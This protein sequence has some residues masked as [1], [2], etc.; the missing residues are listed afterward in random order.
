MSSLSDSCVF[1]CKSAL[2]KEGIADSEGVGNRGGNGDL[3]RSLEASSDEIVKSDS[4]FN[5]SW[6]LISKK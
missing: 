4:D 3:N 1:K 5:R 6:I 2:F